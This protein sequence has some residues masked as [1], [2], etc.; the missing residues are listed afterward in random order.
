MPG[1]LET[2]LGDGQI[3]FFPSIV[4]IWIPGLY[5]FFTSLWTYLERKLPNSGLRYFWKLDL[6]SYAAILLVLLLQV[7][8]KEIGVSTEWFRV[9][10]LIILVGKCLILLRALYAFPQLIQ[11]L[12]LVVLSVGLYWLSIPLSHLSLHIPIPALFQRPVLLHV[13]VL[14]VKAICLSLMTRE[15]FRLSTEMTH[16]VQSAFFGWLLVSFTFPVLGFP[17]IFSI[18]AGLLLVFILR[19]IVSRLDTRELMLGLLEPTSITIAAKFLFVLAIVGTGG[20]VFWSNVSPGSG[21]QG[22]RALEVAVETLFDAQIGLFSYAPIYWLAIFGIV[23]LVFFRDWDGVLLVVTG[24]VLY[25]VYHLALYGMLG[26]VTSQY[27]SV[28]FLSFFGV[29]IAI[30]HHR[31]RKVA[32]F[33]L[34]IRM[35]VIATVGITALLLLVS[36]ELPSIMGKFSEI[37]RILMT[38]LGKDLSTVFP[39]VKFRPFSLSF[40]LWAVGITGLALIC[41]HIRTRT[42]SPVFL[43][44]HNVWKKYFPG[45]EV[46]FYPLLVMAFLLLG[47]LGLTIGSSM[48]HVPLKQAIHLTAPVPQHSIPLTNSPLSRLN[49]TGMRIV[50]YVTNG[51]HIPHRTPLVSVMIAGEGQHFETFTIKAGR[52]TAEERLEY[53]SVKDK[54]A[55]NRAAIYRSRLVDVG[56]GIPFAAREYYTTLLFHK[57]LNVQKITVKLLTAKDV[58]F[59]LNVGVHIK[60]MS[61]LE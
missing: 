37:Q 24:G 14:A 28:P 36:P 56:D 57:P 8:W 51:P 40:F 5:L 9:G 19:L 41:C 54:I 53:W 3:R 34:C 39:S 32:L 7:S 11:P 27:A 59:S 1:G 38:S 6:Y 42:S 50:S 18:L 20:L 52:D 45:Q 48:Y 23:Y 35:F 10:V 12:L 58:N 44:V 33:R 21:L 22:M 47:T 4:T 30:A 2:D 15:M 61:L 29:F 49:S 31:F 16:S 60:E 55:H 43:K 46:R 25:S 13:G 17:K 26:K